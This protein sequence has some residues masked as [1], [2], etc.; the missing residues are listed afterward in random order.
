MLVCSPSA[1]QVSH[2]RFLYFRSISVIFGNFNVTLRCHQLKRIVFLYLDFSP[3]VALT[4]QTKIA[5]VKL[6]FRTKET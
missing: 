6:A 5:N 2:Q 3:L 1:R 4:F